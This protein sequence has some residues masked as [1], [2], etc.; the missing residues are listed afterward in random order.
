MT[1]EAVGALEEGL[2][3]R[4]P[5]PVPDT[6][7][8]SPYPEPVTNTRP[9]V[10]EEHRWPAVAA[11]L[12]ALGLY[13]ALPGSFLPGLRYAVVGVGILLLIPI[14]VVNPVR[15]RRQTSWSRPLSATQAA[16][17][18]VA[19]QVAVVQLLITLV[20]PG[21]ESG[22]R[23][24]VS[25]AQ[26]WVT[27]VIAVALILWEMDRGGPVARST[28][29]RAELPNADLRFAQDEDHDAIDEVAATSSLHAGWLPTFG[30]YLYTSLSNS[31]AFSAS[32]SM[33]L[34]A[35]AKALLGFQAFS[36]FVIL[37]LVI[38]RAVSLLA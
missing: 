10:R 25:A 12:V 16:L 28:T 24:L 19:N 18:G 38:A 11:I 36:G 26:V 17:L 14:L 6:P 2:S 29:P 15:F 8:R 23:L 13:A 3:P 4:N 35:R 7:A 33:P 9:H 30:D 32:D 21:Q 31:M 37:A 34:S 22:A 20:H 27:N 1:S 5:P